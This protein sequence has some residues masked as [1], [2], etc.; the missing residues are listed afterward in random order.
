MSG[1]WEDAAAPHTEKARQDDDRNRIRDKSNIDSLRYSSRPAKYQLCS[2]IAGNVAK[3]LV[4]QDGNLQLAGVVTLRPGGYGVLWSRESFGNGRLLL[5]KIKRGSRGDYS[6][7]VFLD[8]E[9]AQTLIAN[10]MINLH[11]SNSRST[12]PFHCVSTRT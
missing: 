5:V 4:C 7:H 11:L 8:R 1:H 3:G 6:L 12:S 2:T 10:I 9:L